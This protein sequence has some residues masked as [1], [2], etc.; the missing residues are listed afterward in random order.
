MQY[1]PPRESFGKRLGRFVML[2]VMLLVI[3]VGAVAYLRF[4]PETL[5]LLVG[6]LMIVGIGIV[7]LVFALAFYYVKRRTEAMRQPQQYM[8]TYQIPPMII[9]TP[10]QPALP[11]YGGLYGEYGNNGNGWEFSDQNHNNGRDWEIIGGEE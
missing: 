3:V 5:A 4:D 8:P 10:Q 9:Q 11:N 7:I 6:Q 1:Q 2:I